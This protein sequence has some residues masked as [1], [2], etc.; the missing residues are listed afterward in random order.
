VTAPA[1]RRGRGRPV[2]SRTTGGDAREGRSP[3]NGPMPEMVERL[4]MIALDT[5]AARMPVA[6]RFLDDRVLDR[7]EQDLEREIGKALQAERG[8]Q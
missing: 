3:I 2:G 1:T 4:R 8:R 5:I 7:I 6:F